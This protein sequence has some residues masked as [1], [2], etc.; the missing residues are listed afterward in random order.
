V[1]LEANREGTETL[2]TE[3]SLRL[4][5]AYGRPSP[6]KKFHEIVFLSHTMISPDFLQAVIF[7][8]C[9]KQMKLLEVERD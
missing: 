3:K 7:S 9:T 2:W 4:P 8:H 1:T 5:W 6:L